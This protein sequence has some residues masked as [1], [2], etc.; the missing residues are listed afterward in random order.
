M[1][2]TVVDLGAGS[3]G[4]TM[5]EFMFGSDDPAAVYRRTR[6][7]FDE[8]GLG[9]YFEDGKMVPAADEEGY[10]IVMPDDLDPSAMEFEQS[11]GRASPYEGLAKP[12]T[13][14]STP[15]FTSR[16]TDLRGFKGSAEMYLEEGGIAELPMEKPKDRGIEGLLMYEGMADP[17]YPLRPIQKQNF[18]KKRGFQYGQMVQLD[19]RDEAVGGKLLK[20]AGIQASV[21]EVRSNLDPKVMDQMSRIL[22]RDIG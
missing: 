1:E 21:D 5:N 7:S 11:V 22:G 20:Q 15:E 18:S 2:D 4:M 17:Q 10:R 6:P 13:K 8:S 3:S 9:Y 14:Q 19:E 12:L 16:P